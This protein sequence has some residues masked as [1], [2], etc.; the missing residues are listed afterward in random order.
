VVVRIT[1]AYSA[2]LTQ[3][4][5]AG[6]LDFAVVP[7]F[8]DA[9]GLKSRLLAR[10]PEI[11]VSGGHLGIPHGEPVHLSDLEDLKVIVPSWQNTRRRSLETYFSSNGVKVSRLLELDAMLGTLDLVANSD[12]VTILPGVMMANDIASRTFTV[13]P[14]AAPALETDLVL[15]KPARQPLSPAAEIF[16]EMLELETRRLNALW[17]DHPGGK[18]STQAS[19]TYG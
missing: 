2:L 16:L 10:T 4:V 13:N 9:V 5:R 3:Q 11:L 12:W 7:A 17:N 19:T 1:E 6:E 18:R 8:A 15:I 14:L